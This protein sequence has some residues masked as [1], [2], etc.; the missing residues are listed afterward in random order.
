ML[1]HLVA[2]LISINISL[3]ILRLVV[4]RLYTIVPPQLSKHCL[5]Y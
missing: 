3:K 4:S 5:L 2:R 1:C